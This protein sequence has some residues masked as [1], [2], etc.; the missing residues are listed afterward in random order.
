M[1]ELARG[2]QL[3]FQGV[4]VAAI[5]FYLWTAGFGVAILTHHRGFVVLYS[6]LAAFLLY[7]ASRRSSREAPSLL[8]VALAIAAVAGVVYWIH[9]HEALAR[10]AGA[11]TTAD[12]IM[13]ATLTLLC[14]EAARRVL[15]LP[16]ALVAC[17]ALL[18]ATLG[19]AIP[20]PLGHRGIDLRD[21]VE[22]VYLTSEG[23]FGI[24]ADVMA[25]FIVPFI[26]FGVFMLR[27]GV[28]RLFIDLS[29]ALFGR[30]AGGPAQVSVASSA[31]LGS[32]NGSPIANTVTTGSLTIP[33]MKQTGFPPH[34]AAAIEAAA[35]T[36]GMILPPVMGAG[37]FIMAEMTGVSYAQIAAIALI[38]ALLY[39]VGVGIMVY[40][41]SRKLGLRGLPAERIPRL[42]S[43]AREGW[44]LLLPIV[45]LI[46]ALVLGHS[47]P[48]A[49]VYAI[50]ATIVVSWFR[51]DT[52]MGPGGIWHGL[53]ESGKA[54]TYVAAATGA[55]GIIIGIISLTGVGIRFSTLVLDL[56]AG[57]LPLALL[58]VA[59]ASLVLGLA[60]PITAA[61]LLLAVVAAPALVE[62]GL[63]LLTAHMIIFW[64]SLDSN[65][66]PPVA[67]GPFA[68]AA[69]AQ[70]D[71]WRTSWYCFRL[72]KMIY[73][74]P[75][76]FA[77]T[78]IL[79]TG[80]LEENLWAVGSALLGTVAFSI[81]STAYFVVRTT[82]PEWLLLAAATVLAFIPTQ[83]T[84][85]SAVAIFAAV[86]LWQRRRAGLQ[87]APAARGL[88]RS[89]SFRG[90][91]T[92]EGDGR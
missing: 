67:L 65:I 86:Y 48:L 58:F 25:T 10:R 9:E 69:I 88:A 27:A 8:D 11:Y 90:V 75:L 32:I 56:A 40:C 51:K 14:L 37:A 71:P 55:V 26:A 19:Y 64:L 36:G 70:A 89:E 7:G 92:A 17:G 54:V 29:L 13:S 22:Y 50:G 24:M 41:E 52:R 76:L 5:T 30:V 46:G 21:A 83:S 2:W 34:V 87:Q 84:T 59:I 74:M 53:A 33:L 47:P 31:L 78:H 28:A 72:A 57:H 73:V 12:F 77:Y 80:T 60:L 45:I 23:I 18:Y 82:L 85:V 3:V 61:Y 43:V 62:M 35:S 16:F 49:V 66:T 20:G 91:D 63:P 79:F 39:F 68:A 38:P 1:R 15:G 4:A 42:G 6:L 44:Y 81:M